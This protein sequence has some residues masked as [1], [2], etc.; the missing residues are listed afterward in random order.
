MTDD[1]SGPPPSLPLT[2]EQA[3]ILCKS[4]LDTLR[5]TYRLP[6]SAGTSAVGGPPTVRLLKR[7]SSVESDTDRGYELSL[8]GALSAPA[9]ADGPE[10]AATQE[11]RG[12]TLSAVLALLSMA[13]PLAGEVRDDMTQRAE[14]RGALLWESLRTNEGAIFLLPVPGGLVTVD[15]R[16]APLV[17]LA[18]KPLPEP[19]G[20]GAAPF[21]GVVI[22]DIRALVLVH[23]AM[24]RQYRSG[25][26]FPSSPPLP[27]ALPETE[28]VLGLVR[29]V[30]AL[31]AARPIAGPHVK[32]LDT[33]RSPS[34]A[35]PALVRTEGA[36][37]GSKKREEAAPEAAEEEDDDDDESPTEQSGGAFGSGGLG[38]RSGS[39]GPGQAPQIDPKKSPKKFL[40]SLGIKVYNT[41]TKTGAAAAPLAASGAPLAW[42]D[43]AGAAEVRSAVE[44]GVLLPLRHPH[45]Y[46]AV[47]GLTRVR[48]EPNTHG[49]FLFEGPPGTGKTTTAR[50][51]AALADRPLVE[52]SFENIGSSYYAATENNFARVLTAVQAL[53]GAILLVDEAEALFPSR[54]GGGGGGHATPGSSVTSAIGGK[55]LSQ[56]LRFLEGMAG[57]ASN[58][59]VLASNSAAALDPA[60]LSRVASTISFTLPDAEARTAIW[61]RYAKHLP[62]ASVGV[63][64][65]ESDGMSGRDVKRV[66]EV[67][68]RRHVAATLAGGGEGTAPSPPPLDVY[69][70]VL[71]ERVDGVL[72]LGG[73]AG[74]KADFRRRQ[75]GLKW[76][77]GPVRAE[78]A[79]LKVTEEVEAAAEAEAAPATG[80][81]RIPSKAEA[82]RSTEARRDAEREV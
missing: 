82:R 24:A 76:R 17:E 21:M 52:L 77:R 14:G 54:Y 33:L 25:L 48:S 18:W 37:R 49:T 10:D 44:E 72:A 3:F 6:P 29:E 39:G 71:T 65:E 35:P 51:I 63:L 55:L 8:S 26:A 64:V 58:S 20:A 2:S 38:G 15:V 19:G 45:L 66:A 80:R 68:E 46:A 16:K 79:T 40:R 4:V 74:G 31:M 12:S 22:N 34:A 23:A 60:L 70:T 59:V 1:E 13:Y 56:M 36:G 53:P 75:G 69:S 32:L 9:G 30:E 28:A 50:I 42:D 73:A 41:Q 5:T 78:G 81:A 57:G 7:G 62:P 47:T 11:S 61:G 67:A 27:E 43:L